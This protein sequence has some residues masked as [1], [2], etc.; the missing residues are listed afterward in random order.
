MSNVMDYGTER[1]Q[2]ASPDLEPL[3]ADL[4]DDVS[5]EMAEA[6][7]RADPL[8]EAV[9]PTSGP[10]YEL[11]RCRQWLEPA[12]EG[13]FYGWDDVERALAERR[14]QLFPGA[15]A[16]IVTETIDYPNG[17]K[18]MQVWLAGGDMEEVVA[19][20]PGLMSVARM[21]G[22]TDVLV[23]GRKGWERI[24][25]ALGFTFFSTTLRRVL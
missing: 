14:A 8:P 6:L 9:R 19:M 23:E 25:G 11:E 4:A 5:R 10:L 24:L 7:G 12:L 18:A 21:M 16:A 17:A 1:A 22:C 2:R 20:A 13:G 15:A 3:D